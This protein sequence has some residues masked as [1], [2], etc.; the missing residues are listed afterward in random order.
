MSS[1]MKTNDSD[2]KSEFALNLNIIRQIEFFSGLSIEVMKLF[3]L[4]CKRQSYKSGD[5]IF[6]QNEDDHCSYY[7]LSGRAKL[8]L[9]NKG[10]EYFIREYKTEH[11]FGV[12]SLMTPMVNQF[13]LVATQ[14]TICL[15][16]TREAFSKVV[17]Q[18]PKI[19]L[20]VTKAIGQRVLMAERKSILEI[21]EKGMDDLKNLLGVSLI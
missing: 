2:D 18:F 4:L 16:M 8:V 12:L 17:D 7:I 14:D 19:L 10:K 9:K 20:N 15:T 11:Y 21:E 6:Y 13:S 5:V 1:P 3:A